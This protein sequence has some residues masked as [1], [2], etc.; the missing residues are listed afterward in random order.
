MAED[1]SPSS[2]PAVTEWPSPAA[3]LIIKIG[4]DPPRRRKAGSAPPS[5]PGPAGQ[6]QEPLDEAAGPMA[7]GAEGPTGD[8]LNR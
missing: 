6:A 3:K 2:D 8:Q 5:G 4:P 7:R 1:L